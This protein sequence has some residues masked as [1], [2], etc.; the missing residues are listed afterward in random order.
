MSH[1]NGNIE[2]VFLLIT[3]LQVYLLRQVAEINGTYRIDKID[4]VRLEHI[5]YIE[6]KSRHRSVRLSILV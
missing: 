3:T 2:V 5:D 6:V 1:N 4:R